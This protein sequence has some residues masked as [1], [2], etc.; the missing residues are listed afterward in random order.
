MV[1][2]FHEIHG[3]LPSL[4]QTQLSLRSGKI[5]GIIPTTKL[6]CS[7]YEIMKQYDITKPAKGK[8]MEAISMLMIIPDS[9]NDSSEEDDTDTKVKTEIKEEIKEEETVI[10]DE[11]PFSMPGLS[12]NEETAENLVEDTRKSDNTRKRVT[13]QNTKPPKRKR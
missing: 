13:R 9:T 11:F 2:R 12:D 5:E 3:F 10:K 6:K 8:A 4:E 1:N 7:I